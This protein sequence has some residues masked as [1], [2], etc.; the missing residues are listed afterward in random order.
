[1]SRTTDSNLLMNTNYKNQ[2]WFKSKRTLLSWLRQKNILEKETL[3]FPYFYYGENNGEQIISLPHITRQLMYY[4][5]TW[6]WLSRC[7]K[8]KHIITGRI[9]RSLRHAGVCIL[10]GGFIGFLPKREY[11]L[12]N[13]KTLFSQNMLKSIQPIG[14]RYQ[15][16][17]IVVT[18]DKSVQSTWYRFSKRKFM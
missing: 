6:T 18:R 12:R 17:N 4:N 13:K 9:G 1:M 16:L 7:W 15:N 11:T 5:S 10:I 2:N 8:K 14:L 3:E